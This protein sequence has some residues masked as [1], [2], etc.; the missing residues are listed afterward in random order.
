[1]IQQDVGFHFEP[2]IAEEMYRYRQ[3]VLDGLPVAAANAIQA[4]FRASGQFEWR[5]MTIGLNSLKS[6]TDSSPA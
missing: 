4:G 6:S 1:M 3:S 5:G 2:R